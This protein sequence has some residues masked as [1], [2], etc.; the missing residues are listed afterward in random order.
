[1]RYSLD[2]TLPI[3]A[4]SP[5]AKGPFNRGMTLEGGGG[6]WNP[7]NIV[8]D[9]VSSV[10]DVLAKIDPGPAI[11][12][13]G[14]QLDKGVRDVIP[15]GW[16]MVGVLALAVAAPYMAPYLAEM[17]A[18]EAGTSTAWTAEVAA[19][20]QAAAL[21]S[22]LSA[23]Q[24][25][26]L[27]G[28]A[29]GGANAAIRGQDPLK[30]A[31]TGALMG[32]ITGGTLSGLNSLGLN[33]Y[34]ASALTSVSTGLA[35]GKDLETLLQNSALNTGLKALTGNYIPSDINPAIT[36]AA[37]GAAKAAIT[38]KDPITGAVM[39]AGN[40]LLG[41]GISAGKE[42]YGNLTAQSADASI[43]PATGQ[44]IS[45]GSGLTGNGGLI[46]LAGVGEMGTD[47]A[48]RYLTE[49]SGTL[50]SKVAELMPTIAEQRAALLGQADTVKGNYDAVNTAQTELKDAIDNKYNPVYQ[51]VVG[52]QTKAQD[53][54]DKITSTQTAYDTNK[55]A[56]E[57]SNGSDTAAFTAA[58]DAATQ[59]NS[60]IPQ[61][62]TA[63][64]EFTTANT[65]LTDIYN[66]NIKPL[67]DTFETAK[68]TLDSSLANFITGQTNLGKV[69]DTAASY[70][71]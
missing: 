21:N 67:V 32:G 37:T 58:N 27:S 54:Y 15:G 45:E 57:K 16:A 35:Q 51:N 33:S 60:L 52:L 55:A 56:Y 22:A 50:S 20:Q 38:G 59:L 23:A 48:G 14:A 71:T 44:P 68:T 64:Q 61:Y 43:N 17:A 46:N 25:G 28:G 3:N 49:A 5:R 31:I 63:A 26:A 39:G 29:L 70:L 42:L 10:S 19:T 8:S 34:L 41:Q 4:F 18:V 65:Q 9:A 2:S 7:V 13:V 53:L 47:L 24:T 6:S 40:S 1:M 12:N 62:N 11:G 66:S 36:S 69:V 30:G